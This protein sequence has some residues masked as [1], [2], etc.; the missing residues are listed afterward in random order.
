MGVSG[1][2]SITADDVALMKDGAILASGSSK[3]VEID[4]E[5]LY[6]AADDVATDH[7]L[8]RLMIGGKT[9]WLLNDGTP[10]NFADQ[11]VLGHVL[12]LVYTELYMCIRK[13]S[14]GECQPG[15]QTLDIVEQEAIADVW[16]QIYS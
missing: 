12:D 2:R 16:R 15:L 14:E 10:I 3:R 7:G 1:Q 11:G 8:T 13:L 9:I 6:A 5:G 4:V